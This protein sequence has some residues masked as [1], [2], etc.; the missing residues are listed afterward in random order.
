M[1]RKKALDARKRER[2]LPARNARAD[3]QAWFGRRKKTGAVQ[4]GNVSVASPLHPSPE[5]STRA[6]PQQVLTGC[7]L[8]E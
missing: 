3:T 1:H 8:H 5:L 7:E 2:I 4:T 6:G